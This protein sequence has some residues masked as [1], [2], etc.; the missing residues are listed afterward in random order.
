MLTAVVSA[1]EGGVLGHACQ[2]QYSQSVLIVDSDF[3]SSSRAEY[4][5]NL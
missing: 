1:G 3:Y 5:S 4:L 2:I